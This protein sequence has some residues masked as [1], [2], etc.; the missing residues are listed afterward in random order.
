VF[1]VLL[2]QFQPLPA[3]ELWSC[4]IWQHVIFKVEDGTS[5]FPLGVN[6]KL[7]DITASQPTIPQYHNLHLHFCENLV[8]LSLF[9]GGVRE[10]LESIRW[11]KSTRPVKAV[12]SRCNSVTNNPIQIVQHIKKWKNTTKTESELF[13]PH[14]CQWINISG[15]FHLNFM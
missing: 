7:Q 3:L 13:Y 11:R 9:L 4:K 6:K 14:L 12:C 10:I 1:C 5:G 15:M 8:S 2:E